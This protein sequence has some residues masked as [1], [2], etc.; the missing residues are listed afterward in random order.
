MIE[1]SIEN[2][3]NSDDNGTKKWWRKYRS[4]I[5]SKEN[6]LHFNMDNRAELNECSISTNMQG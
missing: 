1:D 5:C 3:V 6:Y 2:M 4:G